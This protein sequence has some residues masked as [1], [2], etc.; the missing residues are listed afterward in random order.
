LEGD[1]F[2][3]V[4]NEYHI[5]RHNGGKGNHNFHGVAIIL[6]PQYNAGWKDAG[7]RPPMTTDVAGKFAG[8]YI[9]INVTLKVGNR[10]F[11]FDA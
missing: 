3:E 10:H 2:D 9:S 8:P 1:A 6:S 4:I 5:F 11:S 7:A